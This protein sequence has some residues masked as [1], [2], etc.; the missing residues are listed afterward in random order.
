MPR[1]LRRAVPPENL[2]SCLGKLE[3]P[4]RY[5]QCIELRKVCKDKKPLGIESVISL[6]LTNG[7]MTPTAVRRDLSNPA[8]INPEWSPKFSAG[9]QSVAQVRVIARFGRRNPLQKNYDCGGHAILFIHFCAM[10]RHLDPH[11]PASQESWRGVA[12]PGLA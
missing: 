7:L 12:R 10:P 4:P 9:N 1:R 3:T 11:Q 8:A 5:T 6:W 2:F